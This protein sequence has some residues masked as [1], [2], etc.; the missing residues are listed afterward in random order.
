MKLNDIVTLWC[1]TQYKIDSTTYV[2]VTN[3]YVNVTKSSGNQIVD[4]KYVNSN[5]WAVL[6]VIRSSV[7]GTNYDIKT[8]WTN[9]T[10]L[11]GSYLNVS[12]NSSSNYTFTVDLTTGGAYILTYVQPNATY[13]PAMQGTDVSLQVFW[14]NS[15]NNVNLDATALG[16]N[17]TWIL[18]SVDGTPLT[19]FSLLTQTG[20]GTNASY[21]LTVSSSLLSGG[22]TYQVYISAT[23]GAGKGYLPAANGTILSVIALPIEI[24]CS[25]PLNGIIFEQL[26][27]S[28]QLND[29]YHNEPVTG[30]NVSYTVWNS[31]GSLVGNGNLIDTNNSNGI[32][33]GNLNLTYLPGPIM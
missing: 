1:L 3:A 33:Y 13:V 31:S 21:L 28:V 17:L 20:S 30:A 23:A 24:N 8:F 6:H 26:P 7:S 2:P 29:T 4:Q 12:I 25:K 5:G 11:D 18:R 16:G 32:Y 10:Q 15:T 19:N 14:R 27:F 22:E 9:G